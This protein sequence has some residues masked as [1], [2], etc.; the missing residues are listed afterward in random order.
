LR[1]GFYLRGDRGR[2]REI[3]WM[4][5]FVWCPAKKFGGKKWCQ[6]NPGSNEQ[7]ETPLGPLLV[8]IKVT[9]IILKNKQW[10]N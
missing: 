8:T 9:Y 3:E 10:R 4:A 5:N 2:E 1:H 6:N 7:E